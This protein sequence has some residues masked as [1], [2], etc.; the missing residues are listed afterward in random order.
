MLLDSFADL[1]TSGFF[2]H[3]CRQYALAPEHEHNDVPA[4]ADLNEPESDYP[5]GGPLLV[6][7]SA[8]VFANEKV[9]SPERV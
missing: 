4:N 2:S 9:L 7:E 8:S 5:E 1:P 3:R 6:L